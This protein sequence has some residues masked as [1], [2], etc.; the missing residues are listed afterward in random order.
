MDHAWLETASRSLAVG[1]VEAKFENVT[2]GSGVFD[3]NCMAERVKRYAAMGIHT[4]GTTYHLVFVNISR[5]HGP[6]NLAD[7]AR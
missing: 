4:I 3:V 5:Y 7:S 6:N 1:T 2:G